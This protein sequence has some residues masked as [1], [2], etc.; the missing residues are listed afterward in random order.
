MKTTKITFWI[1]TSL[2]FLFMGV[3]P[4]LTGHTE[5]AKEGT[6]H[7][8]YPQYF[9]MALNI[10]KIA[11]S[12][13]LVI[14]Q[15]PKTLKEWAYAGF[16]FDIIFATISLWAVDGFNAMLLMPVLVMTILLVSYFSYHK[17]QSSQS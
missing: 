10:F 9:G 5:M 16:V 8:G 12:L 14:P 1:S 11:G 6:K 4:A 15:V 3:M 7:L 13:A 2:I 17:L